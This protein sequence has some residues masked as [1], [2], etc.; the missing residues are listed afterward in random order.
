[1]NNNNS[2]VT[3]LWELSNILQFIGIDLFFSSKKPLKK[4]PYMDTFFFCPVIFGYIANNSPN[5]K[6]SFL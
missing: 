6:L 5:A 2:L 1:M 4:Y 3:F